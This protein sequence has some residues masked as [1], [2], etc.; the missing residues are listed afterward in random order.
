M[1]RGEEMK[2]FAIKYIASKDGK[3]YTRTI[4]ASCGFDAVTMLQ[5][6]IGQIEKSGMIFVQ[7]VKAF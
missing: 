1:E 7:S 6:Q 3:T 4:N 2:E 5:F